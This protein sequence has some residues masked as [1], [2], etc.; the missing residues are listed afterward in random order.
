MISVTD[1]ALDGSVLQGELL[2]LKVVPGTASLFSLQCPVPLP[3]VK[4]NVL[5]DAGS[6]GL[7]SHRIFGRQAK[8][9]PCATLRHSGVDFCFDDGPPND[10]G[11]LNLL[12]IVAILVGNVSLGA[13]AV[14]DDLW[15]R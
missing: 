13:V 5:A 9:G 8:F 2:L 4:L 7:W 6:V 14:L 3:R 1:S 12:A 10:A 11:C 15:G